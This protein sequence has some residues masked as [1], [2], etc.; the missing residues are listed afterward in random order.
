MKVA[1]CCHSCGRRQTDSECF[2]DVVRLD[3]GY[4][5]T[6]GRSRSRIYFHPGLWRK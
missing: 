4:S 3:D 2:A 6:A 1:N 5:S